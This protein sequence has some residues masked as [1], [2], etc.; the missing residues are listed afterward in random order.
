MRMAMNS[1]LIQIIRSKKVRF[2]LTG[3]FQL[4]YADFQPK[5]DFFRPKRSWYPKNMKLFSYQPFAEQ[6]SVEICCNQ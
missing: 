5:L 3:F 6:R 1:I 2:S 4:Q